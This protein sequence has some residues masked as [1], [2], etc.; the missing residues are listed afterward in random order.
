MHK[1]HID[2]NLVSTAIQRLHLSEFEL[3]FKFASAF[4]SPD[5][6]SSTEPRQGKYKRRKLQK[7]NKTDKTFTFNTIPSPPSSFGSSFPSC[8]LPSELLLLPVVMDEDECRPPGCL[9]DVDAPTSLGLLPASLS[10]KG[11]SFPG[12]Y[13]DPP[14]FRVWWILHLCVCLLFSH[15]LYLVLS[16]S[17]KLLFML[18]DRCWYYH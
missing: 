5:T 14:L 7:D 12:R 8:Q 13:C 3:Y 1:C 17:I 10:T 4:M 16:I 11:S 9:L 6:F 15:I 18:S 2:L